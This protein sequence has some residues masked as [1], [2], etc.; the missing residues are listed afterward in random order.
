MS[1]VLRPAAR[2]SGTRRV[3]H[4]P[5][6]TGMANALRA[7]WIKLRTLSSTGWLLL[8]VVVVAVSAAA[9]SATSSARGMACAVDPAKLSLTGIQFDR[10]VV[11]I[12]AVLA[13][14]NE[15]STGMIRVTLTAMPRRDHVLAAKVMFFAGLVTTAGVAGAGGSVL[16]GG[17]ILPSHGFTA[18]LPP[19]CRWAT[20]R[21]FA[22]QAARCFS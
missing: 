7:E 13:I 10:A 12:P 11:A 4:G 18:W 15:Y 21:R 1:T 14:T 3:P 8:A 19:R 2:A 5:P 20:G 6:A 9:V 17:L 16:A 22:R